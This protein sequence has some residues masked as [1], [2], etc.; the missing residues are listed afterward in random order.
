MPRFLEQI[1]ESYFGAYKEMITAEQMDEN[2]VIVS[3]PFH[4]VGNHRVEVAVTLTPQPRGRFLIS[5]M[6]RT[7]GELKEYGYAVAPSL[8]SR[9]VDIA[10]PAKVRIVDDNLIMDCKPEDIGANLHTFAE[11][12]KTIGDAYL[13]YHVKA[14][15]EKRLIDAIREVFAA[16]EIAYKLRQKVHGK[17]DVHPVDFYIPPNGHPGL[18]MGVLGGYN[19][20][21]IAQVWY[22][23]C[24]DMRAFN[25]RLKV[26][27]VYDVDES[28]RSQRSQDILRDVADF[29][30]PSDQLRNLG[31]TVETTVAG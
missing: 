24:Q 27:L 30:L 14:P 5:D 12:A 6:G 29:A 23:K 18:A 22:F 3:F 10:R 19:T 16:R 15:S 17:I 31:E 13:A 26:G 4:Y 2:N 20:H 8:L 25:S 9:M 1:L 21:T 7:I 11:A 28:T